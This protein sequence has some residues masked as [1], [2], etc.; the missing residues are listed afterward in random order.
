MCPVTHSHRLRPGRSPHLIAILATALTLAF[1]LTAT[2][3]GAS[4]S[5][6]VAQAKKL[7]LVLSDLPQGWSKQKGSSNSGS[8]SFPGANKL[9]ACIGVPA[10]LIEANPPQANSP[11][12]QNKGDTL[13]VQDGVSV[14]SSAK[15][16]KA[17]FNAVAN[18]KAPA[19]TATAMNTPVFRKT[20]LSG[21]GKGSQIGTITATAIDPA[22]YA[23]G[24][25]GFV[26]VIPL[27]VQGVSLNISFAVVYYVKG[28]LGQQIQFTSYGATFPP[29]LASA[30]SAVAAH[31]L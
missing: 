5:S 28:K 17:E 31:R 2:A 7:L 14:F 6:K 9:A 12:Y 4:N 26:L 18:A 8:N 16:A 15:E 22:T 13:E 11:T 21:A 30:L 20:V 23:P 24:A 27:K 1:S 3:A 10:K 19:C 29:S 25:A